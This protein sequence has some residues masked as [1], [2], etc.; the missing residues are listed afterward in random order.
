MD[1]SEGEVIAIRGPSGC[2]KTTL[3]NVLSGI[4]EPTSGGVMLDGKPLFGITD[5]ERSRMRAETLG[6]IV[7][8]F[9]LLPVLSAVENVELPLL[10]LG[11]PAAQ[12]EKLLMRHLLQLVWVIA[13]VTAQ[14]S[15]QAVSNNVWQSLELLSTVHR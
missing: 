15:C 5:D 11:R 12:Q 7:Q 8:D 13:A 9:N 1:V 2:G 3:L 10:M 4:D 6:F 14:V